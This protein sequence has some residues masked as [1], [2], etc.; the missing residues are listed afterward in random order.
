MGSLGGLWRDLRGLRLRMSDSR[1][2]G[3]RLSRTHPL[4]RRC[5]MGITQVI[6]GPQRT[7]SRFLDGHPDRRD[8]VGQNSRPTT[9]LT[10]KWVFMSFF[11]YL[12]SR[13]LPDAIAPKIARNAAGKNVT[14]I[15]QVVGIVILRR[16]LEE[17]SMDKGRAAPGEFPRIPRV[18]ARR[19]RAR[20][21]FWRAARQCLPAGVPRP[22]DAFPKSAKR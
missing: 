6:R 4:T 9:N 16:L 1:K 15:R 17:A 14:E 21:E 19:R 12:R 20:S 22:F 11:L 18:R 13:V 10:A 5:A 2:S 8:P 3:S 7:R